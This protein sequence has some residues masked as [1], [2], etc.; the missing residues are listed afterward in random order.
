M[1]RLFISLL[2]ISLLLCGCEIFPSNPTAS[3]IEDFE[4]TVS[5]YH[6]QITKYTGTDK[7]V[8]IPPVIEG[9]P[10]TS[11]GEPAFSETDIES[12]II[13]D[14]VDFIRTS[15]FNCTSLKK[16]V[17]PD[18]VVIIEG[19][20]FSG[21]TSLND[22]SLP[23]NLLF[24][25]WCAFS[26]TAIE[27]LNIPKYASLGDG[28][29]CNNPHLKTVTFEEGCEKIGDGLREFS[30][31]QSLEKVVIPSTAK[32]FVF[33]AFSNCPNL[34]SFEFAG[35]APEKVVLLD[36]FSEKD[37]VYYKDFDFKSITVYYNKGTT[38]W[39]SEFWQIF[40]LVER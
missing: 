6:V 28:A 25:D 34:K 37:A 2:C 13:P 8:V 24:A 20:A 32:Q 3:P 30:N 29:F 23:E 10:V 40:N 33:Y 22:I 36:S 31:C 17:M 21:C 16:V 39:D 19:S 5:E 35:N 26:E 11:L 14:T 9:R 27:A 18:S 1:K 7:D 15:F 38:G 4:Y 12:V